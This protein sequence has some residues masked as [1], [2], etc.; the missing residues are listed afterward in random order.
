MTTNID[1][2]SLQCPVCRAAAVPAFQKDGYRFGRCIQCGLIYVSNQVAAESLDTLYTPDYY[3]RDAERYEAVTPAHRAM[4]ERRLRLI[5]QALS[6][7]P[8]AAPKLLDIGCG[9][10]AFLQIAQAH[11]YTIHGFEVS[12][13]VAANTNQSLGQPCVVS[14]F[15]ALLAT[16]P[17]DVVTIW[18]V[19]EHL[20][21]PVA[22]FERAAQLLRPGGILAL[23]TVNVGSLNKKLFGKR[24]RYFTPPEHLTYF[25]VQNLTTAVSN[26]GFHVLH[27]PTFF[28]DISF[29]QA[30]SPSL[31]AQRG[32]LAQAFK[33]AITL[34]FHLVVPR[35]KAGD[36]V[37]LYARR[38]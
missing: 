6:P 38:K 7:Q 14:N 1:A 3:D 12:P 26:A 37:E 5:E 10:G 23:A 36:I 33:K 34:P 18:A 29:W 27:T 25:D 9:T 32:Y 8:T 21:D 24:W 20:Q 22:Y 13:A 19:V 30:V 17:L 28:N 2:I 4:W 31:L 15:D 35:F 16:K 11:G